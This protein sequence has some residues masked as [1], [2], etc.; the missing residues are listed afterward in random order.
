M[1]PLPADTTVVEFLNK[2][3]TGYVD[4]ITRTNSRYTLFVADGVLFVVG[5]NVPSPYSLPMSAR[6]W[7][8]TKF[9]EPVLY[10]RWYFECKDPDH[11]LPGG[12]KHTSPI[13]EIHAY[14]DVGPR[15]SRSG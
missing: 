2:H 11:Y 6:A 10:E 9:T 8:V 1:S 3:P 14:S 15:A 7:P 5:V 12:G 4:V 13:A